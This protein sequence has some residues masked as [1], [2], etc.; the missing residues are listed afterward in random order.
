MRGFL[1]YLAVLIGIFIIMQFI[2]SYEKVNPDFDKSKE[3]KVSNELKSIFKRSCYDCHS[4]ETDW[5]WYADVAPMK[6]IVRRDVVEGRKALNFSIWE[7]YDKERK[8]KL[9]KNIFRTINL[10]MPLPQ[11]LWFHREAKL[12]ENDKKIIRDWASDGKGYI[13]IEIR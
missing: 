4:Y 11:Y 1:T 9:K 8:D 2:P 7:D 10:A 13:K 5:P 3:I 6:W 12:S